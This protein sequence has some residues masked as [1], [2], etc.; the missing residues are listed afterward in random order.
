MGRLGYMLTPRQRVILRQIVSP[1]Y[2]Y[3]WAGLLTTV[4][5]VVGV[6]VVVLADV[7]RETVLAGSAAPAVSAGAPAG[8]RARTAEDPPARGMPGAARPA[9]TSSLLTVTSTSTER[10]SVA[11]TF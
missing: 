11:L 6:T 5:L 7:G 9:I 1:P 3:R 2:I 10:P 8:I 4:G